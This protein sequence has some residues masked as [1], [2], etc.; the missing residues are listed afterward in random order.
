MQWLQLIQN[1]IKTMKDK[2]NLK[3][4]IHPVP[5]FV[6]D[7]LIREA[8]MDAY[9][10]RPGYQQNDYIGWI[11]SAK[12]RDTKEKRLAQMLEEL[13]RGGIYMKMDH[14]SSKRAL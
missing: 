10:E 9:Y 8:L 14:P 7:A 1:D 12:R 5:E 2:S 11:N 6:R 4:Q 3:R 13:R